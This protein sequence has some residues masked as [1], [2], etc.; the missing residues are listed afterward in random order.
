MSFSK[1]N[2]AW[3]ET[4]LK[5]SDKVIKEASI[6]MFSNIIND[7]P[8]GTGAFV[9]GWE[10]NGSGSY[11]KDSTSTPAAKISEITT[12]VNNL[13][14][15]VDITMTNNAPYGEEL[16]FGS[17]DKAPMGFLRI[18]TLQW[19]GIVDSNARKDLE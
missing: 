19:S 1:Q 2:K 18:N 17:S 8:I 13:G 16:E 5:N 7:S 11:N 6:E 14:M 4:F 9:N 10:V 15:N 3:S 12:D